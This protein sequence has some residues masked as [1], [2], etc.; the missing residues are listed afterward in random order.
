M[1]KV[2]AQNIDPDTLPA[3]G[4]T[5]LVVVVKDGIPVKG[6]VAKKLFGGQLAPLTTRFEPMK[7][8]FY[9]FGQ[10][11]CCFKAPLSDS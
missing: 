9:D 5:P 6:F 3:I 4:L 10:R 8:A 7:D 2:L 11:Y 1:P